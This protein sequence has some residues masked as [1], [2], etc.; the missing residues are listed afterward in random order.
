M[1]ISADLTLWPKYRDQWGTSTPKP[2][3]IFDFC[4]DLLASSVIKDYLRPLYYYLSGRNSKY[5]PSY[6]K[7]I[8]KMI[9]SADIII[10]GSVEQKMMLDLVHPN[11]VI[12]RD[13]FSSDIR[14]R[15]DRYNLRSN[16]ELNIFWEGFSHGNIE[17]FRCLRNILEL[18]DGYKVNLHIV[19]DT[20][21][22]R[23]GGRLLSSPTISILSNVFRGSSIKLNLYAWSDVTFSAIASSCDFALIPI[24]QDDLTMQRKPENKMLL[25]WQLGLPVVASNTVAYARVMAKS[26]LDYIASN[27][28]EW[29]DLILELAGSEEKRVEYM[30]KAEN[31]LQDHCSEKAILSSWD[32]VFKLNQGLL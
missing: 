32:Q 3:V 19:T 21:Y 22:C 23:I 14:I 20:F 16:N 15:K 31:Y 8:I 27:P 9:S 24:P 7:T 30:K 10:C 12:I 26:G 1:T 11:V 18:I 5:A 25:L 17:I 6:K 4:D 29:R 28:I 2:K 13:N